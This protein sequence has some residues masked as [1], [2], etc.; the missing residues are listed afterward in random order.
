MHPKI[1][2]PQP[3]LLCRGLGVRRGTTEPCMG[4]QRTRPAA[5]ALPTC[6]AEARTLS[7]LDRAS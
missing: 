6:S 5:P 4:C 7:L 2:N 1:P 3:C